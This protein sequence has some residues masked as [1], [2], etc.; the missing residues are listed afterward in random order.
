MFLLDQ[1]HEIRKTYRY[2]AFGS[3]LKE[4]GD[5]PNRL[6]Y[7]GQ[8]YDGAAIQYY[9]RARFYNPAIGRFMQEDTYR[10]DGLNLYAYCANNPVI[11]YDPSGHGLC[12]GGK[13]TP[14]NDGSGEDGAQTGTVWDNIKATQENYPDTDIPRSFEVEVN[15]QKMWVHGNATEHIYDDVYAKIAAGESMTY[16]DL[17]TQELMSDFY[18]SLGQATISGIT[19]GEKIPAGN[20]EFIFAPPRQEGLLPVVK[21]AQFNG[22]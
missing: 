13:D 20:W 8:I 12:P 5:I 16:V 4:T 22:W 15:G 19:Y 3:L 10:G 17:Y 21:H 1:A 18:G 9:L 11:Y 7:T 6:T 14:G 2:D